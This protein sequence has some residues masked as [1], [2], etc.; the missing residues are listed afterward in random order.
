MVS[1]YRMKLSYGWRTVKISHFRRKKILGRVRFGDGSTIN[2][3][4]K[5]FV[6]FICNDGSKRVLKDVHFNPP[7]C[8]NILSIGQLDYTG[9][10][11]IVFGG[12]LCSIDAKEVVLMYI[13]RT[14]NRLYKIMLETSS[15][16]CLLTKGETLA[17]AWH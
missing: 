15:P 11:V 9:N 13:K 8:N 6:S 17:D 1:Q 4:G 3:M 14:I 2:I 12:A 7:L 5:G 10:K 16:E